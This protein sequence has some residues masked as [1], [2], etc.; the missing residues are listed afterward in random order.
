MGD[1][2]KL[3]NEPIQNSSFLDGLQK[4]ETRKLCS[5][6]GLLRIT[7]SL[8]SASSKLRCHGYV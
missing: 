4:L 7:P 1:S 3:F 8:A 5:L 2:E 6:D